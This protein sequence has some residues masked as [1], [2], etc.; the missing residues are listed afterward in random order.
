M[1]AKLDEEW[2]SVATV[3]R[4]SEDTLD[5]VVPIR[6]LGD[7][8]QIRQRLGGVPAVKRMTV[9]TL[10]AERADIRLEFYGTPEELQRILA[11]AGLQLA[12]EASEWRLQ[13]R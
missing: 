12:R 4:D 9:R 13:A 7:W 1:H 8:V 5:V 10:E 11:Q 3:R 6:T 2:R